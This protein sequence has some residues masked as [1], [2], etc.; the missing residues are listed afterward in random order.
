[1][2][3]LIIGNMAAGKT[4]TALH[5][6][7]TFSLGHKYK[8]LALDDYRRKH[9]KKNTIT[10]EESAQLKMIKD[11]GKTKH[12]L[13]ESSG[14]GKWYDSYIRSYKQSFPDEKIITVKLKTSIKECAKRHINREEQGYK[15]PPFPYDISF[16]DGLRWIND[17]LQRRKADMTIDV[18]TIEPLIVAKQII[19][20]FNL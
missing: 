7:N 10:G 12:L 5:L 2:L 6:M 18:K 3:I 20:Q 14:T 19:D 11:I 4:A 17:Q 9:N 15:L 1:M 16:K 8:Y 13:L